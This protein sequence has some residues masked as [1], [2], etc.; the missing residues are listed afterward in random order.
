[1]MAPPTATMVMVCPTPHKPP[2]K[3]ASES[4][5]SRLTI[6]VTARTWSASVA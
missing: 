4:D 5:R 3:A 2:I 1:M 6:V